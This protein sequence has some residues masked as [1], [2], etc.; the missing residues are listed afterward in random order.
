MSSPQHDIAKIP[1]ANQSAAGS[2][3]LSRDC[4]R[5]ASAPRTRAQMLDRSMVAVPPGVPPAMP[6]HLWPA[7][8]TV[9]GVPGL[10]V[11]GHSEP[12]QTLPT[13]RPT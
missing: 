8:F 4:G 9:N 1:S 10:V 11:T 7:D 13:I 3:W 12:G 5:L 6:N 2:S